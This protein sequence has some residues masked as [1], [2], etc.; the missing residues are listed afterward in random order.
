[1]EL[2]F[3]TL[4]ELLFAFFG[5]VDGGV[6]AILGEMAGRDETVASC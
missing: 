3:E 2:S 5:V 6:V 4:V 1:M